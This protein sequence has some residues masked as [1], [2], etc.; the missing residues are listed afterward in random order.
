[1]WSRASSGFRD[2]IAVIFGHLKRVHGLRT[3]LPRKV[4]AREIDRPHAA[5]P[6]VHSCHDASTT[7][8]RRQQ[9]QL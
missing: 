1:M 3:H 7:R 2:G 4:E 6:Y 9:A 8:T 5:L